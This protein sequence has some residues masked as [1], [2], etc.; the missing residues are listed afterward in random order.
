MRTDITVVAEPRDT[1]GKNEANRLRAKGLA[2]A[3]VYGGA[4]DPVAVSVNPREINKI[5][6]SGSGTNTIFDLQIKGHTTVPVMI[7][8]QQHEPVKDTLL[9][10]DLKR[11]DL[12]KRLHVKIAVKFLGDPRGVKEQGGIYE[13]INREVEIECLPDDIPAHF[14]LDVKELG[15]NATVRASDLPL[16]GSMK[17][18]SAPESVLCHVLAP[19]VV[20]V[21]AAPADDKKKKK[22]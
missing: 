9:H 14:D 13:I 12:A 16:T 1:R 11:I 8:D 4:E 2:P 7:V 6:H 3:V 17:L 10:V 18:L 20:A 15:V 19:K 22:K 5:L 21:E